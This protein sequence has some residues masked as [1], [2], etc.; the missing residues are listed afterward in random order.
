MNMTVRK[1]AVGLLALGTLIVVYGLYLRINRTPPLT[2]GLAR[3]MSPPTPFPDVNA[4]ARG[5]VAKVLG[6]A[7]EEVRETRFQHR[8]E[9]NR[10]DREFG[11]E[12]LLHKVGNQYET[13]HPYLTLFFPTFQC[14]VTANRGRVQVD[15]VFSR[16]MASDAQFSGNVI[17]HIIPAEPNDAR[18]CYIHLDDVGFLAA[19]SLFSSEGPVRFLSRRA[20]LTGTGLELIYDGA[21]SRLELFRIF[22]L[23]TLRLQSRQLGA[24]AA[25]KPR[26]RPGAAASAAGQTHAPTVGRGTPPEDRYQCIFHRNVAIEMPDRVVVARN[27][28]AID[29]ILWPGSKKPDAASKPTPAPDD[30]NA[31]PSAG[32]NALDTTASSH[33]A[34]DALPPEYFDTTVTCDGGFEVTPMSSGLKIESRSLVAAHGAPVRPPSAGLLDSPSGKPPRQRTAA[35]RIQFNALT[36]DTALEGPV[37]MAFLL[38]PNGLREAKAGAPALPMTLTAQKDVRFLAAANQVLFEG[39]CQVTLS[40]SEPNLIYEYILTA[41]QLTLDIASDANKPKEMAVS[42]RRLVTAGGPAAL[43][44]LRKRADQLV[45]W[46]KVD[47]TQFRYETDPRQ[48]TAIGPGEIWTRS[49]ETLDPKADPNGFSFGRPCVARLSNFD[50]LTYFAD[51]NRIVAEDD[52]QQLLLDYFPLVNGQ[53]ARHTRAVVSHVEAFLKEITKGRLELAALQATKGIE[54]EDEKDHF[55]GST[56]SYD[57][58]QS[59]VAV[60]GD[61]EQPCSLNGAQVD[62]IDLNLKTGRIQADFPTPSVFRVQR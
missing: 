15:T 13:A 40:R 22:A 24:L 59:L 38:D 52:D 42:A 37:E 21:R 44:I 11:F 25:L 58:T 36:T 41:P 3:P 7:V 35:Q 14:V 5:E 26:A 18:E 33:A 28:L 2:A 30:A 8:D 32:H 34:L 60:R 48:F 51:T 29:N 53:Y 45:G 27:E 1:L 54:Y 55:D 31:T 12:Q 61:E 10:V 4:N 57:Y 6:T 47:A 46:T 20:Q 19:K 16:P 43:R 17:I 23:D 39:G 56:L 62:H 50:V 49:D 9:H